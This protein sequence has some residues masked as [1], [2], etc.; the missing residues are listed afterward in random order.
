[1][2]LDSIE[3]IKEIMILGKNMIKNSYSPYSSFRV[4]AVA[5]SENGEIFS[6]CNVENASY[7]LVVC[8]E[9]SAI[10]NMISKGQ[11]RLKAMFVFSSSEQFVTPCG[12]CRQTVLEFSNADTP[13][14][15]VNNKGQI[16][17]HLLSILI[18]HAF[19]ASALPEES[20]L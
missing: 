9:V 5:V 8:A 4:G 13:I 6:G 10:C 17:K 12:A 20:D 19:S 7:S 3:N 1:M 16:R 15:V 11:K 2:E 18:P 14:F